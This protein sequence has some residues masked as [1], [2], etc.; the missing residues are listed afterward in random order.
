MF[1]MH[2]EQV[3]V[4]SLDPPRRSV[5]I[6]VGVL[7]S[8]RPLDIRLQQLH[9]VDKVNHHRIYISIGSIVRTI[10]F[11]SFWAPCLFYIRPN[12]LP[13]RYCDA[14]TSHPYLPLS[15]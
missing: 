3:I 5:A 11:Y 8:V 13:G 2:D 6:E 9:T 7:W 12:A 10:F 15:A 4:C 1:A 14:D